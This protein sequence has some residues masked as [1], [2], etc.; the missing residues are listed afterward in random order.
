M[1]KD[2]FSNK[3]YESFCEHEALGKYKFSK[4]HTKEILE[5]M[6]ETLVDSLVSLDVNQSLK[7]V[8]ICSFHKKKK[9]ARKGT[10]P[11]GKQ[12]SIDETVTVR[13]KVGKFLEKS[14]N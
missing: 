1:N 4:T 8:N 3:L 13:L 7:F 6:L 14:L 5:V 9:P 2:V 11:G 10:V 12:F